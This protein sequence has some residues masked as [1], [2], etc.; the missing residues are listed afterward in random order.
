M[1]RDEPKPS[2]DEVDLQ[3]LDA[4]REDGRVSMA[5][6]AQRVN[7]SRANAHMRLQRL[8][9]AG[10]VQGFTARIHSARLGLGT[11]AFVKARIDQDGWSALRARLG[12]LPEVEYCAVTAGEFDALILVRLRDLQA[13]RDLVVERLQAMPEI[14][15]TATTVVLDEPIRWS[16][17][18]PG[19]GR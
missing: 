11:A 14:R 9:E 12:A 3:I 15:S 19:V 7:V 10:V 17:V 8:I 6:L 4:L 2:V 1:A 5:A 18:L 13:L 16:P